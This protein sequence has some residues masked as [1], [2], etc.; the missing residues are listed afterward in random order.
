MADQ[1]NPNGDEPVRPTVSRPVTVQEAPTPVS[2]VGNTKVVACKIPMGLRIVVREWQEVWEPNATGGRSVKQHLPVM[3]PNDPDK[4]MEYIV[5]GNAYTQE[6][7][8]AGVIRDTGGYALTHGFPADV[9]ENWYAYNKNTPLVRN[10]MIEAF[11]TEF[12]AIAWCISSENRDRRSG[13]ERL[14]P[15]H[16]EL[17]TGRMRQRNDIGGVSEPQRGST[18]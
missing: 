17:H 2:G 12:E 10:R 13:L 8:L 1:D 9:W 3:D 4:P 16:P 5:Q 6:R 15:E 14:D 7:Q 11:N 18:G